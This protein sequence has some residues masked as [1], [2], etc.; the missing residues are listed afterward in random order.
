LAGW[1]PEATAPTSVYILG[2]S[3]VLNI[4]T[5]YC[6]CI[7]A[8]QYLNRIVFGSGVRLHE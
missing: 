2:L 5:R 3:Q 1:P 7:D 8:Q 4:W 6:Y